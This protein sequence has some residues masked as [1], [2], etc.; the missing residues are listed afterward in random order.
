MKNLRAVCGVR[1]SVI[2]WMDRRREFQKA[3]QKSRSL[4]DKRI[5]RLIETKKEGRDGQKKKKRKEKYP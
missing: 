3:Y 1:T 5:H 4:R 2:Q